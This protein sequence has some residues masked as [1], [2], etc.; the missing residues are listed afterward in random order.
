MVLLTRQTRGEKEYEYEHE[1]H[2]DHD[3]EGVECEIG[4]TNPDCF[5]C[6]TREVVP[7]EPT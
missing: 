6:L 7:C 3:Y 5:K 1:F 4:V 2:G